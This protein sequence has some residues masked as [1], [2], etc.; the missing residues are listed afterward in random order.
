MPRGG[1]RVVPFSYFQNSV[2]KEQAD[3][4]AARHPSNLAGER[5]IRHAGEISLET[6]WVQTNPD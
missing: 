6:N 1:S 3:G 5:E 2:S 4:K